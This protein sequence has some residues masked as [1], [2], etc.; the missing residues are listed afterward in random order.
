VTVNKKF[1]DFI[2]DVPLTIEEIEAQTAEQQKRISKKNK[3][4]ILS[5]HGSSEELVKVKKHKKKK[6]KKKILDS[7]EVEPPTSFQTMSQQVRPP[8][9]VIEAVAEALK[10]AFA[11]HQ[12]A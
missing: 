2:R 9:F 10:P 12:V 4:K 3:K 7:E 1:Q 6:N 5:N 11:N 8:A